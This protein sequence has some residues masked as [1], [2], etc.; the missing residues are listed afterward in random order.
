MSE[1]NGHVSL[2][3]FIYCIKKFHHVS[4]LQMRGEGSDTDIVVCSPWTSQNDS[5][6]LACTGM[7]AVDHSVVLGPIAWN[8]TRAP[9][10]NC[11]I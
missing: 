1:F 4:Q 8:G 10:W 11:G 5:A 2:N 9:H 6:Q 3:V 7:G